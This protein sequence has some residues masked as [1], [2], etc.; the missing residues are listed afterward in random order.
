M[1]TNPPIRSLISLDIRNMFNE[2]SRERELDIINTYFLHLSHIANILL[3]Q[4]TTCY[5]MIPNGKWR[6]FEQKECHPQGFPFSPVIAA[7]VLNLVVTKL[8]KHLR[9]KSQVR[10]LQQILLDDR[11]GRITN[12]LAFVDDL[13]TVVSHQDC[14]FYC[15]TF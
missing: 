3:L 5:Y 15:N 9:G 1:V 11:E 13:N 10:K 2:I 12:L 4:S 7:L 6:S 14:M 8:D